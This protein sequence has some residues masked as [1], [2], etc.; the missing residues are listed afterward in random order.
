VSPSKSRRKKRAKQ[1]PGM[2][3]AP[4]LVVVWLGTHPVTGPS[5]ALSPKSP[6]LEQQTQTA[7][8]PTPQAPPRE[9]VTFTILAVVDGFDPSDDTPAVNR[10]H[11]DDPYN[12]VWLHGGSFRASDGKRMAAITANLVTP[13]SAAE[14]L[15]RKLKTAKIIDRKPRKNEKGEIFGERI[16]A[17]VSVPANPDRKGPDDPHK[18]IASVIRTDGTFYS[19]ISANVSDDPPASL[20]DVLALEQ[21]LDKPDRTGLAAGLPHG[22]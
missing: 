17:L 9:K 14:Y 8:T 11:K 4:C 10:K 1:F 22:E 13:A 16:V 20:D 3:L 2:I 19:A 7:N 12:H 21:Y 5:S 15:A 6:S 18:T